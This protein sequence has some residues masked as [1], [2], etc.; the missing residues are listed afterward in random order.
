MTLKIRLCLLFG[1]LDLDS[2]YFNYVIENRYEGRQVLTL[3]FTSLHRY[4]YYFFLRHCNPKYFEPNIST[5]Q[6]TQHHPVSLCFVKRP[7]VVA[8]SC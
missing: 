4:L 2:W 6:H 3:H 1:T 8:T 5:K 7:A